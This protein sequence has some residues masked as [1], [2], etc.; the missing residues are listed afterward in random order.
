MEKGLA[1]PAV[2]SEAGA[3]TSAPKVGDP[4]RL[5]IPAVGLST[6][7]IPLRLDRRHQLIAPRRFDVAGWNRAG[8]EPGERGAA[9]IAGHVDSAS[10]PAVFYRLA[11]L[12]PGT[13]V[14]VDTDQGQ[15]VSFTVHHLERHPKTDV[16]DS[17]YRPTAA[18]E[19]RLI[20]C[21]GTFDHTR[22]SYRDNVIVHAALTPR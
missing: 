9:V 20:T 15:T 1:A 17:V 7:L 5:R 14:Y 13:R 11:D 4:V 21:G 2:R 16:P 8:P 6:S 12:T 19:L 22:G 3:P 10:G 18:P